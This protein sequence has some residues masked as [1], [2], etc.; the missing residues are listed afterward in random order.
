MNIIEVKNV[1]K[2]Y[3]DIQAVKNVTFEVKQN[4]IFALVGPNGAG[5]TT[6]IEMI[7]GLRKP[8]RG[9][10]T[11]KGKN[12]NDK[13]VR[14]I[15]G[16]QI[17]NS[18]FYYKAKVKECIDMFR[19]FYENPLPTTEVLR[20][21]DI[22]KYAEAYYGNLSG[23]LKQRVAIAVALIGN[24][25]IL[26]LDEIT[27]GLDPQARRAMWDLIWKL[28][29]EG[30]TIF[31]TTHYMEEAEKLA[32]RVGIMNCGEIIALDAPINLIKQFTESKI[33]Y[34]GPALDVGEKVY[35]EDNKIV[36]KTNNPQTV[37]TNL[38]K[39]A[40]KK[41]IKIRNLTIENSHLEDV[42]ISL[43]GKEME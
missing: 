14:Q 19:G 9:T 3:G 33:M 16:V 18:A 37:I 26:F 15:I 43:T 23:G 2:R 25:E 41:G 32:D 38:L 27:T 10:I 40:A 5:K 4:E 1:S 22:E 13:E 17:Q 20:K 24:P 36:I 6:L 29:D 39:E 7:E 8:D 28:R 12:P 30:K 35:V 11:I 42:Y 21:L 34:E 31:M